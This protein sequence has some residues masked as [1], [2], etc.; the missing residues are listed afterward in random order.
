MR[1]AATLILLASLVLPA[2][3][4]AHGPVN[5][6]L[7]EGSVFQPPGSTI[8]SDALER[9]TEVV[10]SA[11][12]AGFPIKVAV[13]A[14]ASDLGTESRLYG[15]PQ[16]YAA[17]LS[18]ELASVYRDGLLI[19]M[20]NGFGYAV[21]GEPNRQA[22]RVLSSLVGPGRDAT[23]QAE[24]ATVAV[25]RLAAAAGHPIAPSR[26]ASESRDRLTV[27]AAVLAGL[28]VIAALALT[29]SRRGARRG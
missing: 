13:I 12:R 26:G 22:R 21:N 10:R 28:A 29:R 1:R 7:L 17:H 15:K 4:Q 3:A 24:A 11:E 6:S 14:A 19:V 25:R 2:F 8:D 9:L 20:P 23:R 27:T 16:R 5:E 18:A